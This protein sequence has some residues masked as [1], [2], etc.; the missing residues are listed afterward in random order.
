VKSRGNSIVEFAR[1]HSTLCFTAVAMSLFLLCIWILPAEVSSAKGR[2]LSE[3]TRLYGYVGSNDQRWAHLLSLIAITASSTAVFF[4]S[5]RGVVSDQ[6]LRLGPRLGVLACVFLAGLGL[7]FYRLFVPAPVVSGAAALTILFLLLVLAAPRLGT[8]A[9]ERVTIAL[10]GAYVVSLALPGLLVKPIPLMEIDPT[11]LVQF[12]AH[13]LYLPMRGAMVAAGQNFLDELPIGYG[14]L[15]PSIMSVIE[16]K[17]HG[18]SIAEQLRFVQVCQLLF[19]IAAVCAYMA[20]KPR[21]YLG[22]L[23]ALLL[24]GPYWV[25][26]GLGIWHPNQTGFRS[27]GL[28][29]GMLALMIV[30]RLPPSRAAWWLGFVAGTAILMNLETA[31]ALSAGFAVFLVVRTRSLPWMP[32]LRAAVAGT[33]LISVYFLAFSLALRRFPFNLQTLDLFELISRFS[34]GDFGLRL[35]SAGHEGEGFYLV[36][37]ALVMFG[38]AIYVVIDGFR[39]LGGGTLPV[40][41]ALRVS[42]AVTLIL[43]LAYY[44]NAPNWWQIWTHLFLY[45]FLIIDLMDRRRIGI[46]PGKPG[47]SLRSRFGRLR[48]SPALL[49]VLLLLSL[50]IPHTNRHLVKYTLDFMYP[51]WLNSAQDVSVLS[52]ILMPKEIADFLRNKATKLK[53][54]HGDAQGR[55]VYFTFNM[56]SMPRLTGLFQP[57]PYRD[58]FSEIPGDGAFGAT[59]EKLFSQKPDVILLDAPTGDYALIGARKDFQDRLRSAISPA[60]R[61]AGIEDGWQI[62]RRSDRI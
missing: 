26:A 24:A 60:Y 43:W 4:L 49:I 54:L 19:C 17:R 41:A 12:E 15:M 36:P 38:H 13:L 42:V 23:V 5:R 21:Q 16:L 11:A 52:G 29:A 32:L 45:G 53:E 59:I 62:W 48:M 28:P 27:L 20:Y 46:G 44:F 1:R 61:V 8:P 10:I 35:F 30:G 55:L 7:F 22:V 47:E 9:I 33:L 25:T 6:R 31:I 57:P 34:G 37:F 39:R 56:A 40:R 14:V 58:M 3:F 50:L 2:W 18:L 51:R